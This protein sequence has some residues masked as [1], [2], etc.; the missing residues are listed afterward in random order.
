MARL[1]IRFSKLGKLRWTSHRDIAR[2]WE[3]AL[4]RAQIPVEYSHGF[5][6]RPRIS[7]G[8]ALPT[9]SESVAEY[10]DIEIDPSATGDAMG[11][12]WDL[13]SRVDEALPVGV[14]V[15]AAV[16]S[17]AGDPSLQ[18]AVCSCTW[19]IGLSGLEHTELEDLLG[20]AMAS[21]HLVVIRERKARQVQDDI[22]PALISAVGG[23]LRDASRGDLGAAD[24]T[25]VWLGSSCAVSGGDP[26]GSGQPLGDGVGS[27]GAA[28]PKSGPWPVTVEIATRPRG[29]RPAELAQALAGLSGGACVVRAEWSVRTAQWIGGG[30]SARE[31]IALAAA[32]ALRA[33]ERAS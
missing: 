19:K 26:R 9:G 12:P 29:A 21:S 25:S 14:K 2:M 10:L 1:R 11:D 3:R 15:L 24:A 33:L 28:V 8:L 32:P 27:I 13:A 17:K 18:E 23:D 7:F 30:A 20:K 31:P 6:P 5:T 4:R 16:W 22:R